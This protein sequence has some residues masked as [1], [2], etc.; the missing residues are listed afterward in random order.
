MEEFSLEKPFKRKP[1]N[2][3]QFTISPDAKLQKN[4][5]YFMQQ[6]LAYYNNLVENFNSR[7][8][9]FPQDVLSIRD[10]DIKLLETCGQLAFDPAKLLTSKNETW[11]EALKSYNPVVY[12]TDGKPRLTNKQIAIMQIGIVPAHIHHQVRKNMISEIFSTVSNQASIFLASRNTEQLRAP[13]YLL[14]Q[15]T[16]ET[17]R[18]LQIP[19]TLVEMSYDS[20]DNQTLIKTPYNKDPIYISGYDLTEIPFSTMIIRAPILGEE[21][22]AWKIDFKDGINKYLLNLTDSRPIKKRVRR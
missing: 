1:T 17:K 18:H 16:W 11:P 5:K 6:E 9:A 21:K 15:H 22:P 10:R 4:F 2:R 20:N 19:K 12:G 13:V 7:I 14:Q 8:K 3:R